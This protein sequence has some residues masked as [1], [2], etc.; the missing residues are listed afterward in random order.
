MADMPEPAL[1][2]GLSACRR[3]SSCTKQACSPISSTPSEHALTH[4]VAYGSLLLERR[5][6]LHAQT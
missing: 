3:A 6:A 1:R 5:R 2:E 4:D